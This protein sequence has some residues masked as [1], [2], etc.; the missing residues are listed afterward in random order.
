[1]QE[2]QLPE[3]VKGGIYRIFQEALLNVLKHAHAKMVSIS[4]KALTSQIRLEIADDGVGFQE[5]K[6]LPAQKSGLS[7]MR[8]RTNLLGG[9]F[10]LKSSSKNGTD[11]VVTIPISD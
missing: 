2:S 5:A 4:V 8:E 3:N 1:C 9:S 10:R 7:A 11:I 6:L